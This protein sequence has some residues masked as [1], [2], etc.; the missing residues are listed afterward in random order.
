[1]KAGGEDALLLLR[2][3][4][5]AAATATSRPPGQLPALAPGSTPG[6]LPPARRRAGKEPG[7]RTR[8]NPE[9]GYSAQG[10]SLAV[11]AVSP[12]EGGSGRRFSNRPTN[13]PP[14]RP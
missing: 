3:P 11:S 2:P 7:R 9:R 5:P 1:M 10:R 12:G 13:P 4:P 8:G 6:P 14:P